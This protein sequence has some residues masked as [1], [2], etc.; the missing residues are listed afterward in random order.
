MRPKP[1]PSRAG[2]SYRVAATI[3]IATLV[4][5]A[6]RFGAASPAATRSARM[7]RLP[8]VVLWAWERREDLSFLD[9]GQTAV[10]YLDRTLDLSGDTVVIRPRFQPLTLPARTILIPVARIETD[11]RSPPSLS[12]TQRARASRIIAAMAASSLPA[13]QVDFDAT[14]SQR[15]FYRDLIADLRSRLPVSTALS[16]T[17]LVSWCMDDDWVGELRVD[18]IVPML[19]R[20]GPGAEDITSYLRGGGD[21]APPLA[22][23]SVGLSTDAR[24]AGLARGK[25]VYL[26]SP[27][28]WTGEQVR[29]ATAEAAR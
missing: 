5:G 3:V 6:F 22:R 10:A 21:F 15:A 26:F 20:M 18:E 8:R 2:R 23:L 14:R 13:I 29:V 25:R 1:P 12:A 27:R 28:G 16:I 7:R 24:L 19:Y 17:A 11:R 4:A 9:P